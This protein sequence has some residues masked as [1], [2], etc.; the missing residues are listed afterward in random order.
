MIGQFELYAPSIYHSAL[1]N[2]KLETIFQ[3]HILTEERRK[4][5][6]LKHMHDQPVVYDLVKGENN[7]LAVIKAFLC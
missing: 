3:K 7:D 1:K 2:L 5:G 6:K 4:F